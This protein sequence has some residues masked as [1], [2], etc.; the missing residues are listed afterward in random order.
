MCLLCRVRQT[1]IPALSCLELIWK[2]LENTIR[3]LTASDV[4][5]VRAFCHTNGLITEFKISGTHFQIQGHFCFLSPSV[6]INPSTINVQR[7]HVLLR[8]ICMQIVGAKIEMFFYKG[9]S[10]KDQFKLCSINL[11]LLVTGQ[12]EPI[13]FILIDFELG[14]WKDLDVDL[15]LIGSREMIA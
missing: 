2:H 10:S 3:L 9:P 4:I 11:S 14:L 7:C 13:I 6:K 8:W 5:N 1:Y 12:N 15:L